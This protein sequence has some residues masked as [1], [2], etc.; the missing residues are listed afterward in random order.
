MT[1]VL[2]ANGITA[3]FGPSQPLESNGSKPT[4]ILAKERGDLLTEV[5]AAQR[6]FDFVKHGGGPRN[7]ICIY[8]IDLTL[9]SKPRGHFSGLYLN[10]HTFDSLCDIFNVGYGSFCTGRGY[11]QVR[12]I[13]GQVASAP[14]PN[15]KR[16]MPP[17]TIAHNT[18]SEI[19]Y[20]TN[21]QFPDLRCGEL[22]IPKIHPE[23][24]QPIDSDAF[25][26]GMDISRRLADAVVNHIA[27]QPGMAELAGKYLVVEAREHSS[28][29]VITEHGPLTWQ[30]LRDQTA[31]V[32]TKMG[33]N[34]IVTFKGRTVDQHGKR[35]GYI[36]NVPTGIDK[37]PATARILEH[38]MKGKDPKE[39]FV[40]GAGDN[41]A[42]NPMMNQIAAIMPP[43]NMLNICVGGNQDLGSNRN[44]NMIITGD[45]PA[46]RCPTPV[47]MNPTQTMAV[48]RHGEFIRAMRHIIVDGVMPE[49]DGLHLVITKGD[50]ARAQKA[51]LLRTNE[52]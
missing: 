35:M 38:A 49:H 27:A 12:D 19:H 46:H 25:K 50:L 42:E 30:Y 10:R 41:A 47:T 24:K 14:N 48:R 4:V 21:G 2:A 29:V 1:Q 40:I 7:I 32:C 37:A 51:M 6:L 18:G 34:G 36:D 20:S 16:F 43:D 11:V 31:I 15:T 39:F 26:R 28:A 8:D 45:A 52:R 3:T 23:T 17:I 44:V 33:G 5:D 22:I 13:I 9:G